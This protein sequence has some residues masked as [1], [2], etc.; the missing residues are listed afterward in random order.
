KT[1]VPP[2]AEGGFLG[3]VERLGNK[4]PDPVTL[5]LIGTIAVML[6][7]QLAVSAGWTVTTKLPQ[8]EMETV[9]VDGEEVTRPK[10]DADGNLLE[11]VW[12]VKMVD[13]TDSRDVIQPKLDEAG[14]PLLGD[15]G[16]PVTEKVTE[17]FVKERV[18][19][20]LKPKSLLSS[21]GLY[22]ALESLVDNFMGFAPLGIVL[23][24]M[25]GIGVAER[26]G[27]IAALLKGFMMVVPIRYLT[28]AMVFLGVMSSAGIDA[29]YV[30]LPPLA[31]AL[32][33]AAGRS[34][35]AGLAAVFAGVAA[36]FN[37]NLMITGLDPM[38]AEMSA[39]GAQIIAPNYE[40]AAT[41]NWWFAIASTIV[42]TLVGWWVTAKFIEPRLEGKPPEEGGPS[43]VD[44]SSLAQQRLSSQEVSALRKAIFAAFAIVGLVFVCSSIEGWPLHGKDGPFAKWTA[45]IVPILFF[46]FIVPSLTYGFAMKQVKGDKQI[47]KLMIESIAGMAPI[48]VL[49]FFAG[50]F[51]EHFKFS[52]LDKM[53]ALWG[54]QQL[55]QAAMPKEVLVIAFIGMT[56]TFN[57]FVGSMSAKY[58]MFAPIFIPMFMMVGISPELTQA[59][60]RVGDSVSNSIT[61]L[62][63]YMVIIL[64]FMQRFVPKGGMGTLISTMLPYSIAFGIVWTV[65]IV[66]WMALGLPLGIEGPLEF[67]VLSLSK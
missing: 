30:V 66:L 41:C 20:V 23:V 60:Y 26:V 57:M 5:F 33:M 58:A 9:T 55:G 51:I 39:D 16:E 44:R 13:V 40:V 64:V 32:Y 67:D 18:P 35:L 37:A 47:A 14:N 59:A 6:A 56:M 62:N 3:W 31:A 34:P 4:L 8:V 43:P 52:G 15:D 50:Q 17:T 12:K 53:L 22:W 63:P 10:S 36:G 46:L 29:G 38:L 45:A 21:E 65:M 27:L 2:S 1:P 54:G 42:I 11:P 48:V 25:L 19:E 28:P 7:S 61:P 49:A 24:G